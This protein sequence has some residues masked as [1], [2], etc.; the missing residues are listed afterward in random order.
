M[1]SKG[2]QWDRLKE[3]INKYRYSLQKDK[4][5]IEKQSKIETGKRRQKAI[6]RKHD[7]DRYIQKQ[8]ARQRQRGEIEMAEGERM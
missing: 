2:L 1:E 8:K 7:K 4:Y 5:K 6:Q 3:T